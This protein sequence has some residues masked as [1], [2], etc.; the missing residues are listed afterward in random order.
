MKA[1]YLYYVA[2]VLALAA[3]AVGFA[4]APEGEG[5][6]FHIVFLVVMAAV[7]VWLGPREG[8]KG[9]PRS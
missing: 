6:S 8:R 7:L 1:G 4:R 3:A 9:G 5:I 2:A